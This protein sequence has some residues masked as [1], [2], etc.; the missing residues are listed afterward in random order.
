[1]SWPCSQKGAFKIICFLG[2][3][4][5]GG[6]IEAVNLGE[7]VHDPYLNTPKFPQRENM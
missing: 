5:F 2:V 4:Y 6:S 1:M 3:I 7:G